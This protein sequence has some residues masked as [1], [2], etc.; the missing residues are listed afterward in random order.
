VGAPTFGRA[1]R[2]NTPLCILIY[3][4]VHAIVEVP[5]ILL[6]LGIAVSVARSKSLFH[7]KPRTRPPDKCA[8]GASHRVGGPDVPFHVKP[9]IGDSPYEIDQAE[10]IRLTEYAKCSVSRETAL[11]SGKDRYSH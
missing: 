10:G 5:T 1:A 2:A 7:V 4:N 11:T 3:V 9:R 6:I 8:Y